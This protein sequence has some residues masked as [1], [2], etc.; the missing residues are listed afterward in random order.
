LPLLDAP[1]FFAAI[2]GSLFG[3]ALSDAQV[4]GLEALLARQALEPPGSDPRFFAYMLATVH[5]ETGRTMQPI[6]EIG[7]PAYFRRLYDINGEKPARA[8]QNGNTAPGD[9]FRYR[10]RGFVQL[11]WKNN[12][13]R[14]GEALGIDLVASPDRA[15]ELDIATDILFLGM[16]DGWFTG[17][18]LAEFFEGGKADWVGAR[19]IINGQDRAALIAGYGEA[20][21][22]AIGAASGALP[23]QSQRPAR[24]RMGQAPRTPPRLRQVARQPQARPRT[25]RTAR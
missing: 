1:R 6:A 14:A 24:T 2:R 22:E 18:R 11:T 17:R 23:Q 16:R 3:G 13:R 25:P 7:T 21:A 10:G 19:R 20:Y 15:L 9:G 4:R 12:Y 8:R 5:H